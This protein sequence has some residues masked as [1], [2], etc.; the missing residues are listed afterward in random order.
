MFFLK[1]FFRDEGHLYANC[2][3]YI[4]TINPKCHPFQFFNRG[5]RMYIP[6]LTGVPHG[7]RSFW[8]CSHIFLKNVLF[9]VL[10]PRWKSPVRQFLL[11]ILTIAPKWHLFSVL[12]SW[13]TYVH[14]HPKR[15]SKWTHKSPKKK[16]SFAEKN[17]FFKFIFWNEG[18][19]NC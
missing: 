9:E 19:G 14:S 13:H 12:C 6:I 8:D 11:G 1:L 3:F 4:L 7:R 10:F 18:H 15:D 16:C 17:F 2:L 5:I